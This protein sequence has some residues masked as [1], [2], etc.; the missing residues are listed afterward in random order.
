MAR[1][2]ALAFERAGVATFDPAGERGGASPARAPDPE[3]DSRAE[4][5]IGLLIRALE[6]HGAPCVLA[7]DE[8][9][10]LR[11]P[12]A[13]GLINRLVR[14][15]PPHLHVGMAFRER[16]PGLAVDMYP[17]EGRGVTVIAEDLR[18]SKSDISRF[19]GGSL[20][21]RRLAAVARDSAGWPLALRIHRDAARRGVPDATGGRDAIAGWIETRLWRGLSAEDRDF[22]LD[23]ALFDRLETS[24][25][26]E[27]TDARNAGRRIASMGALAGLL[28]TTGRGSTMR[29]HPLI[30]RHCEQ[31]RFEEEPERFRAIHRGIAKALARRGRSIEALR[32]A[33]EAADAALL[34]RIAEGTGGVR[35]WFEQG[36]E[37]LRA[38]DGM[39]TQA[40]VSDHPRLALV[41]CG[42]LAASGDIEEARRLYGATAEKTAGYTRDREGGDDRALRT[43]HIFIQGLLCTL[44]CMWYDDTIMAG[45][46]EGE[47]LASAADTDSLVRGM[48]SLGMC[49]AHNQMTAFDAAVEWA[50]R[51]RAALGRASPY[52]AHVDLQA[53]LVAMARGRTRQAREYY[54]RALRAA[55]A[56]HL[57]DAGAVMLGDVLAFELEFER[58][59]GAARSNR[60]RVSPRLLGQCGAWLDVYAAD[61]GVR[62]ETALLA[63]GPED[64]LRLVEN[65]R[66]YARTTERP[67]LA[68]FLSALRVSVLLDGGEADEA[69]RAWRFDC[70]PERRAECLDLAGQSWREMEML[71][72]A[73]LRLLV[74]RGEFD[75]AREFADALLAV[76]SEHA[77]VRTRMRGL[78]VAMVL[79]QR[80]GGSDRAAAHLA[81]YLRLFAEADYARP[82]ARDRELALALLD[83]AGFAAG[84]DAAV[85]A[86]AGA[87]RNALCRDAG[88]AAP[89]QALTEGELEVLARLEHWQDKDIARTLGLSYDGVRYRVRRIFAKLGARGRLDAVQR[90]RQRG[91][92]PAEAVAG[93]D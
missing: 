89:E 62:T 25:I 83:D 54:D 40:V 65:A 46:A 63:G 92:L 85:A 51:A 23:I 1:L 13:V 42:V 31:R 55:R 19:F 74:V 16:P 45:M 10:R 26:D 32:H 47:V 84:A 39:L 64:A 50:G 58:T 15:A 41:R 33:A 59:A 44:G 70:L 81:D 67:Q 78:A 5:R 37:V 87:L 7:L 86:A 66:E 27:V 61:I 52:Q 91:I 11:S 2:L 77:L 35:L 76:A 56:N 4:Y 38:L 34:G 53:G 18:F 17:L 3:A 90:A 49:L 30:K 68:R 36:L 29:L 28:S 14:R 79:E 24:L 88:A 71:A 80:A 21:R 57:R 73:R 8:V 75:A 43:D 22:V 72:C 12:E 82:L 93:R 48:F 60:P 69:A 20:S 6:Q 9:E